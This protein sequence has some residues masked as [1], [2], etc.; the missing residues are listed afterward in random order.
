MEI[1]YKIS[2]IIPFH[3]ASMYLDDCIKSLLNQ[4]YKNFEAIFVNDGST[5]NSN[6]II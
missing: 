5:D 3:N 2:V 6:D 4:T 1:K